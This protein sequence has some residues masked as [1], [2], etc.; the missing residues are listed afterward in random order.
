MV[1]G[2]FRKGAN[3]L[4]EASCQNRISLHAR[5]LLFAIFGTSFARSLAPPGSYAPGGKQGLGR[6]DVVRGERYTQLDDLSHHSL[7]H[8]RILVHHAFGTSGSSVAKTR[9]KCL[10]GYFVVFLVPS[11]VFFVMY[12]R[13]GV[14][15]VIYF[16]AEC[17]RNV[18]ESLDA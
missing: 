6:C 17:S 10:K 12:Y 1:Y 3:A 15:F 13:V 8:H 18:A 16:R 2:T 11:W 5:H 9:T 7:K 4:L 14:F